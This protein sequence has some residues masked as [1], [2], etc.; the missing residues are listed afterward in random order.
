MSRSIAKLMKEYVDSAI[1][2][3][4]AIKRYI[5]PI[6]KVSDPL[7][8]KL[9]VWIDVSGR[10][11]KL[12]MFSDIGMLLPFV[13]LLLDYEAARNPAALSKYS[14]EGN[15]VTVSIPMTGQDSSSLAQELAANCDLVYQDIL[16]GYPDYLRDIEEQKNCELKTIADMH[17]RVRDDT[18]I[19]YTDEE[20][21]LER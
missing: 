8:Q 10:Y 15:H 19:G 3:S 21:A 16:Y 17:R 14:I 18:N 12:Y 13:E 1:D 9:N 7:P 2:E 11:T 5:A 4:P 20:T 6:T